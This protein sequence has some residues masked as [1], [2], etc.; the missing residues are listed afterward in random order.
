MFDV[1]MPKVPERRVRWNEGCACLEGKSSV[2][3]VMVVDGKFNVLP[4]SN[5]VLIGRLT[6][7]EP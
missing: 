7:R 6:S 4:S 5:D 3:D 2:R 1:L